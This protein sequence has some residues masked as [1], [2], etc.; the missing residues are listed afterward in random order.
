MNIPKAINKRTMS[1]VIPEITSAG[2]TLKIF[3]IVTTIK[4]STINISPSVSI[5]V[6]FLNFYKIS[7]AGFSK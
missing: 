2:L 6:S 7:G 5:L 3:V 4:N 1:I